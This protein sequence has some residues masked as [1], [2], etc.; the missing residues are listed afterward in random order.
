[1]LKL[2]AP[3]AG[4]V[5][6]RERGCSDFM[7]ANRRPIGAS[8]CLFH[9]R[10][11]LHGRAPGYTAAS[12]RSLLEEAALVLSKPITSRS[13]AASASRLSVVRLGT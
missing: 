12:V 9:V 7:S 3:G 4:P 1:M 6:F 5:H 13:P 8:G 11:R 2:A 10:R